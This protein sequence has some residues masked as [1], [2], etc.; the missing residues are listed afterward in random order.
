MLRTLKAMSL[1]CHN[2]WDYLCGGGVIVGWTVEAIPLHRDLRYQR[3][4][5]MGRMERVD[6]AGRFLGGGGWL[7]FHPLHRGPLKRS[8]SRLIRHGSE[9]F[10]MIGSGGEQMLDLQQ[11]VQMIPAPHSHTA[12]HSQSTTSSHRQPVEAGGLG[13]STHHSLG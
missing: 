4:R 3:Q 2:P 8:P 6:A 5:F 10:P 7:L 1:F 13:P 11:G 12:G 9:P